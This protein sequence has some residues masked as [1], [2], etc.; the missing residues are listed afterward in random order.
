MISLIEALNYSCLK[1]IRQKL[2]PFHILVGPNASGKTTFLDTIAF[3]GRLVSD[4]LEAA[5]DERT[6]NFQDLVWQ[7][8]EKQFQLVIEAAIP[9]KLQG[10]VP[11]EQY[12]TV[13]YEVAIGQENSG[14]EIEILGETVLLKM[15]DNEEPQ[16]IDFF[17]REVLPPDSILSPSKSADRRLVIKKSHKGN[18]NYYSEIRKKRGRG[19]GGWSPSYR[20]GPKKSAFGNVPADEESFRIAL[21]LKDFLTDGVQQFFLNSQLI[22]KASPPKLG[23]GFKTD[24]SNLPWVIHS[25]QQEDSDSF[26]RWVNHLQTGLTGLQNVHVIDRP[27]DKHRYLVVEYAGGLKAPSWMVSDGTLR[28]LALTMPAYLKNF[29]G[30]YMIEEPEN[31]IHPGAL[32]VIYQSLSSVYNAQVLLATHSPLI[33]GLAEAD[34]VLC[35]SKNEQG[36]TDIILGSAHPKLRDW[37]GET[38]LSVLFAGGVLS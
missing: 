13:R 28:L 17:P 30:V 4:G 12:D 23:L 37:Q 15:A 31:G 26:H 19:R 21:W 29:S 3:L 8:E 6:Q 14:D 18:D 24:G 16:Q 9:E 11:D 5:I 33:L 38:S 25:L 27:D 22:R 36:A 2:G 20:L 1:Y 34:K 7:R 32:E 10:H 35:F